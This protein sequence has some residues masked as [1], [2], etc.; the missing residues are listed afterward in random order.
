MTIKE[1][2][3]EVESIFPQYAEAGLIDNI[4]ISRNIVTALR[5]FG[6]NIMVKSED[7]VQVKGGK[8]KLPE[9]FWHLTVAI[10]AEP[11]D[12]KVTKG[13]RDTLLSSHFFRERTEE[14]TVW[15]YTLDE[16]VP[17][18]TTTIR[19]KFVFRKAEADFRYRP[20]APLKPVKAFKRNRCSLN[21]PY[22][23]KDFAKN[24]PYEINIYN[25]HLQTN[26]P[27]GTIYMQYLALPTD[28][29]GNVI[30]P[31][32][33]HDKLRTYILLLA[34]KEVLYRVLM[35]DDD[36][37]VQGKLQLVLQLEREAKQLAHTEAKMG[38]LGNWKEDYIRKKRLQTLAYERLQPNR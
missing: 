22:R 21:S 11:F 15:N 9:D 34:Q 2:I 31:E 29:E 18:N 27:E 17:E 35:S 14:R 38:A 4:S 3:A 20:V 23:N 13:T 5:G 30:I 1:V 25:H 33:Q 10:K 36:V 24:S 6:N 19:E 28:D 7:F 26:F 8:A 16:H 12:Y 37:N 32:T